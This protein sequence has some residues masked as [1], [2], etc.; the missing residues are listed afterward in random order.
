[1]TPSLS[2]ALA[3]PVARLVRPGGVLVIGLALVLT[4]C[5]SASSPGP[6]AR[7][8]ARFRAAR[9][10]WAARGRQWHPDGRAP[11]AIALAAYSGH[12]FVSTKVTVDGKPHARSTQRPSC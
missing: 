9:A 7:A 5:G 12:A 8:L 11:A 10:T 4:A 2:R 3:R 1:M 6:A